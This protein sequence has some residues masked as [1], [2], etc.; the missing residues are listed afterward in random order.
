[1]GSRNNRCRNIMGTQKGTMILTTTHMS[2]IGAEIITDTILAVPYPQNA[3][4]NH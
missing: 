2:T 1:M 4:S 3:Y